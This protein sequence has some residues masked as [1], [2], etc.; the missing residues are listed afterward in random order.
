MQYLW[1]SPWALEAPIGPGGPNLKQL[2]YFGL[3]EINFSQEGG[4]NISGEGLG[5]LKPLVV[6]DGLQ[7]IV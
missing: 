5:H 3:C 4:C 1:G 2:F 7:A 6:P